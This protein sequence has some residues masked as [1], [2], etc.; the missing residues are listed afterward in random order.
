[1]R[2]HKLTL[3]ELAMLA[4]TRAVLGVGLSLLFAG[5]LNDDQR[6]AAGWAVL[7]VGALSTIPVAIEVL[8]KREAPYRP[9][10]GDW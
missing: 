10:R 1:M 5:W 7:G 9:Q 2:E 3:P 6:K 8:G 4:G